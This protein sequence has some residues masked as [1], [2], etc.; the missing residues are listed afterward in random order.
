MVEV[1]PPP[2]RRRF[3]RWILLVFY[4]SIL[5]SEFLAPYN[6]H[7]RDTDLIYAPPQERALFH[8]GRFVGPFVYGSACSSTWRR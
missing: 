6:L 8:E 5:V 2:P 3:R 1:P 7:T 4:A